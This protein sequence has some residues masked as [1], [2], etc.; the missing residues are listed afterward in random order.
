MNTVEIFSDDQLVVA[1]YYGD[2]RMRD[3]VKLTQE[4]VSLPGY[5]PALKGVTDQRGVNLLVTQE[6][7]RAFTQDAIS[8]EV[9][10]GTWCLICDAPLTTAFMMMFKSQLESRHPVEV[11]S[12]VRLASSRL[13]LDLGKYLDPD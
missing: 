13:G 9:S 3:I 12:T 1:K 8:S 7:M 2:V 11:V 5:S 6:E 10:L 4:M